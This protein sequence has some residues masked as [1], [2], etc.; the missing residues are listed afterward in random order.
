MSQIHVKCTWP[1]LDPRF[2]S[3]DG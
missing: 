3:T 2:L 1:S